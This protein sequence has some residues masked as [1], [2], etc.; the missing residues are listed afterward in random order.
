[1]LDKVFKGEEVDF[2]PNCVF[3]EERQLYVC[4]PILRIGD[5]VYKTERDVLIKI[6]GGVR[7]I[8]DDGGAHEKILELLDKHFEKFKL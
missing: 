1:M 7:K 8:I 6:D 3:D 5:K 2:R 4:K